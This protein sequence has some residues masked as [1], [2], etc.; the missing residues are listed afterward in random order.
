MLQLHA[1]LHFI[2]A[3]RCAAAMLLAGFGTFT[4]TLIWRSLNGLR[5]QHRA[6]SGGFSASALLTICTLWGPFLRAV[7]LHTNP[8]GWASRPCR[9]L[10]AVEKNLG[11]R[12]QGTQW[13]TGECRPIT[14]LKPAADR[15]QVHSWTVEV[16]SQCSARPS[17]S[18]SNYHPRALAGPILRARVRE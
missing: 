2:P 3:L 15:P 13:A 14:T 18:G 5:L 7:V 6:C 16:R 1:Q 9:S 8:Y 4:A 12:R 17:L 11:C 10:W